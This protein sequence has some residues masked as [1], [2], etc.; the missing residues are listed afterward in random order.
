LGVLVILVILVVF[1]LSGVVLVAVIS[2]GPLLSSI[3]FLPLALLPVL[4]Q[5]RLAV[6]LDGFVEC[7]G[8]VSSKRQQNV[9]RRIWWWLVSLC[10][11]SLIETTRQLL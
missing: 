9:P 6:P 3:S 5:F 4:V 2:C 7:F 8:P 10:P 1:C 11:V